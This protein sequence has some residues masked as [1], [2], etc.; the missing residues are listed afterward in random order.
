M[1]ENITFRKDEMNKGIAK[2]N[3][4]I[5]NRIQDQTRIKVE[6]FTVVIRNNAQSLNDI[7]RWEYTPTY[8]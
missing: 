2:V 7:R 3:E 5:G 1:T 8:R 4:F 6:K